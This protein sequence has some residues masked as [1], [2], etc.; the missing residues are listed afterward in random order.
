MDE[1]VR[2]IVLV[3]NGKKRTVYASK[4]E[5][6]GKF[7][8]RLH[9]KLAELERV[10]ANNAGVSHIAHGYVAGKN[11]ITMALM[12]C[13]FNYTLNVDIRGWYDH[14]RP[15][16]I[17]AGLR[18]A[19]LS[20]EEAEKTA[21]D[22]CIVGAPP[23]P[24][25]TE[26]APRQGLNSSP[27]AANLAAVAMD[28]LIHQRLGSALREA[29]S[30]TRWADD[31]VVSTTSLDDAR[32]A[33]EI[34]CAAIQEQGWQINPN[35]TTLQWAGAG[36]RII[37][38]VAVDDWVHPTRQTRRKLRAAQHRIKKCPW[39]KHFYKRKSGLAQWA[40]LKL[41]HAVASTRQVFRQTNLLRGAQPPTQRGM[42]NTHNE[43][44]TTP[45]TMRADPA[46][47]KPLYYVGPRRL[48]RL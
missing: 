44:M 6:D 21:R 14:I 38:G 2:K 30:Y 42:Q 3:K 35:K 19:G 31:L 33:E 28:A 17:A 45:D 41:P 34:L 10:A 4:N 26:R 18:T 27:A 11:Q 16:Q 37:V 12:H 9:Y 48:R 25:P 15:E 5:D 13:G 23:S 40:A 24:R 36:R 8:R 39:V 43:W 20:P 29:W 47:E 22:A 7:F 46:D 1:R 32:K